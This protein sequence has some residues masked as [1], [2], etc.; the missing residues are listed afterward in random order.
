M[1]TIT[2]KAVSKIE[3]VLSIKDET[4]I[5]L[6][7][8]PGGCAGFM[9]EISLDNPDLDNDYIHMQDGIQIVIDKKSLNFL[10]GS[11]ID[12]VDDLT[13]AGIVINNPNTTGCC[14]C[15]K[16]FVCESSKDNE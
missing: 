5:R 3:E 2:P 16:S 7:I 10:A 8:I 6:K 15:D 12:Y 11:E 13:G 4:A 14:G 1:I 9:Y